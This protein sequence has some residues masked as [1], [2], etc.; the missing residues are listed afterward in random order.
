MTKELFQF[1]RKKE[2]VLFLGRE[3]FIT[4]SSTIHFNQLMEY[5]ISQNQNNDNSF[6]IY[7]STYALHNGLHYNLSEIPR[8]RIIKRIKMRRLISIKNIMRKLSQSEI[9]AYSEIA[10]RLDGIL[11]EKGD[12][13]TAKKKEVN[14]ERPSISE[15]NRDT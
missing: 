7:Q 9:N 3:L 13:E 12:D 14:Q 8:W 10:L 1:E 6:L 5:V 2:K 15:A 11:P 4:E